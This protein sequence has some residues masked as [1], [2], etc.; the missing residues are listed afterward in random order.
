MDSAIA[1]TDFRMVLKRIIRYILIIQSFG[2]QKK[3]IFL[4]KNLKKLLVWA[5]T[6]ISFLTGTTI[7]ISLSTIG[8]LSPTPHVGIT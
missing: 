8:S 1:T 3:R 2:L 4:K 6:I 7:A 5:V